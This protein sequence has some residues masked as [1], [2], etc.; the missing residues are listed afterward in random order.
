MHSFCFKATN[1]IQFKTFEPRFKTFESDGSR[2]DSKLLNQGERTIVSVVGAP[3]R[4][5]Q[6]SIVSPASSETWMSY[7]VTPVP[8]MFF[9]LVEEYAHLGFVYVYNRLEP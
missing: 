4:I 3:L 2:R 8:S 5:V 6:G 9:R 7:T 1:K